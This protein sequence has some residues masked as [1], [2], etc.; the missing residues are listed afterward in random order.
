MSSLYALLVDGCAVYG[1]HRRSVDLA[2]IDPLHVVV[3]V[4]III[5]S[6]SMSS[7]AIS[8]FYIISW[9][10]ANFRFLLLHHGRGTLLEDG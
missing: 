9:M 8:F 5:M 3:H 2:F 1:D 4:I 10:Q 7:Y 6:T